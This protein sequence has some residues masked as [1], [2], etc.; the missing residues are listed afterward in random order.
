MEKNT[1]LKIYFPNG[2]FH[3][4]RY[5]PSTTIAVRVNDCLVHLDVPCGGFSFKELI[6]IALKGRLSPYELFYHL[7]FAIRVI[8][9]GKGTQATHVRISSTSDKT[10]YVEKWL[11]SKMTM[12]K[13]EQIYGTI[14]ELKYENSN[15]SFVFTIVIN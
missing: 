14:E 9:V 11:H 4:I 10:S 6:R 3:G 1:F 15:Q 2:S 8:Y 13:V 12:D 7:S 5:T